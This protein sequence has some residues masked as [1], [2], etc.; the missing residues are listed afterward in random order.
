MLPKHSHKR[1]LGFGTP[2]KESPRVKPRVFL[3]L[4]KVN[5]LTYRHIKYVGKA[6]HRM[7]LEIL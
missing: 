7:N 6:L 5:E 2:I 1:K 4:I 3:C